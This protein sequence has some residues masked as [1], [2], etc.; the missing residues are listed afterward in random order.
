ML[1][2]ALSYKTISFVQNGSTTLCLQY[3]ATVVV[4]SLF[5]SDEAVWRSRVEV[6]AGKD[7]GTRREHKPRTWEALLKLVEGYDEV[8]GID[9]TVLLLFW[10]PTLSDVGSTL[11]QIFKTD[12]WVCLLSGR[13]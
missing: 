2:F 1:A 8:K 9:S 11:W 10:A 12:I 7:H 3:S 5:C 6:R 13:F 4:V